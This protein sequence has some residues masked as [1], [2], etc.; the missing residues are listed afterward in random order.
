MARSYR[1]GFAHICVLF[2][3]RGACGAEYV[4]EGE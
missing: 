1:D 4:V 2:D 3:C